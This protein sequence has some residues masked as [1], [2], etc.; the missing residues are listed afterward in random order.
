[1]STRSLRPLE[2]AA[3]LACPLRSRGITAES[4][5]PAQFSMKFAARSTVGRPCSL[6]D[7]CS[8]SQV[9]RCCCDL[10]AG[11]RQPT[12]ARR[13][14]QWQSGAVLVRSATLM[15]AHRARHSADL[16]SSLAAVSRVVRAY[17][18]VRAS[19]PRPRAPPSR[20]PSCPAGPSRGGRRA[21]HTAGTAPPARS[22]YPAASSLRPRSGKAAPGY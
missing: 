7:C 4:S 5:D 6:F 15:S 21:R 3:R 14:A 2:P 11:A 13:H 20:R 8:K 16:A 17:P 18:R 1:M 22:A 19:T 9:G 12:T 10:R